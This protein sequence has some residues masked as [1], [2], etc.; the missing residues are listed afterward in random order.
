MQRKRDSPASGSWN[1]QEEIR[2]VRSKATE[3]MLRT[4]SSPK[5][6]WSSFAF[7]H[8][9][10]SDSLVANNLG[11][12]EEGNSQSSKKSVDASVDLAARPGEFL[13]YGK[14]VPLLSGHI[15]FR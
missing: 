15:L 13:T 5:I 10:G 4:L 9:R 14:E 12:A 1:I 8:K 2:K 3:E 7:E 6:D 11:P